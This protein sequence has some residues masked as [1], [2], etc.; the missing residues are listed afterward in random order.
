M[1]APT[2]R[3]AACMRGRL[4]AALWEEF[5]CHVNENYMS[6]FV[7]AFDQPT[8]GCV[9][10]LD[11]APCPHAIA[12]DLAASDAAAQLS[13]E[14]RARARRSPASRREYTACAA[15]QGRVDGGG[16]VRLGG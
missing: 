6:G 4:G 8:L 10:T 9:G 7:R 14:G 5:V 13:A 11:G 1:S 12:V 2:S 3:P 15:P 16:L